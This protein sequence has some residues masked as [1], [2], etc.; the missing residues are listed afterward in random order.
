MK[1]RE[2]CS[3]KE[4]TCDNIKSAFIDFMM[5]EKKEVGM[6]AVKVK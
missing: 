3:V 5:C 6:M 2:N 1:K 4:I